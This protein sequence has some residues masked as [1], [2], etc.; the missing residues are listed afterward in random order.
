MNDSRYLFDVVDTFLYVNSTF[1]KFMKQNY[2][3]Y[4]W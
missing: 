2:W 1:M 3:L 4:N